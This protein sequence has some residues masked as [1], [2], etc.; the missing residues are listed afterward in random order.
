MGK[1]K[2]VAGEERG[3]GW[4]GLNSLNELNACLYSLSSSQ[5]NI[6]GRLCAQ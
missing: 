4:N 3:G 6:Y 5:S 1:D 2:R